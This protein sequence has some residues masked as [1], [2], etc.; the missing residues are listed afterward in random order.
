MNAGHPTT[1]V[2]TIPDSFIPV[3]FNLRPCT[4]DEPAGTVNEANI[5]STLAARPDVSCSY[6]RP[7]SE[8]GRLAASD[9]LSGTAAVGFTSVPDVTVPATS[10]HIVPPDRP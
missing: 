7:P 6:I 4:V 10:C 9:V 5:P 3:T 8:L 2:D 1:T